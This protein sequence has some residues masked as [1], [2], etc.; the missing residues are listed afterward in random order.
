MKTRLLFSEIILLILVASVLL[1]FPTIYPTGTTIYKPDKCW[2][3]FT[4]LSV[5]PHN[6]TYLIDMN[7]KEV[8][9]WVGSTGMPARVYPGGYLMAS[10]GYWSKGS[11]DRKTLQLKDFLNNIVWEFRKW[12][13]VSADPG[14]PVSSSGKMWIAR[15]HHDYQIAGNPV[16]YY[17]P[18]MEPTPGKGRV[19]VLAH[20]VYNHPEI[21]KNL[22]IVD[23]VMY[24]VTQEGQIIWTW[25][26]GDHFKE[27]GFDSDAVAAM[28]GIANGDVFDWF[29]QNC[30]SYLG[31]NKWYDQ[32][33][34]RF[35]PDNIILDSRN[36]NV[37]CIIS[38]KT[39]EVVWQ[40][41]P[42]YDKDPDKQLG[43]MIGIHHTHMI[44]K[45]LPG[46]GNIL[47]YDNGGAAGYG[48]SNPMSPSGQSNVLRDYSRVIE[49]NPITKKIVWEY[50]P[51]NTLNL[52]FM[53]NFRQ[54]SPYVSSAQR[55]P[56]GNTMICEGGMGRVFEI[57]SAGELVWEFVNPY[58]GVEGPPG[59]APGHMSFRAY[60]L[61]YEWVPQLNKP[62][63]I[64]VVPPKYGEFRIPA[65]GSWE[66]AEVVRPWVDSEKK[67]TADKKTAEEQE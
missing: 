25:K 60:R 51:T 22:P 9:K 17:V 38:K 21:N 14:E 57:T 34:E 2:N 43:W 16:G 39:G 28:Q 54:Y 47:V 56:N 52:F 40:C 10:T 32:G 12:E 33:D 30:A 13:E 3:G 62:Q 8:H 59:S 58:I 53:D 48:K 64:P 11:Q 41:G 61:P 46:E 20:T 24:E 18:G 36:A 49:F 4:V 42:N 31:P 65:G 23:D 50:S 63:E 19:L 1:A 27:F 55:L 5:L 6:D 29:H 37:L 44:P 35:H 26:V 15:Q 7:G 66:G 67:K 45:G